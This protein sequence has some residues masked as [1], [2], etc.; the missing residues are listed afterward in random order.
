MANLRKTKIYYT[1][2]DL[3]N[4]SVHTKFGL[5]LSISFQDIE[6]KLNY[7]EMT[8]RERDRMMDR[9]NPEWPHFYNYLEN[10]CKIPLSDTVTRNKTLLLSLLWPMASFWCP[11]FSM[12]CSFIRQQRC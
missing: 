4:D 2:I 9:A 12:F 5:N 1:N 8:E 3:F 6:Q 10:V 11:N 7:A